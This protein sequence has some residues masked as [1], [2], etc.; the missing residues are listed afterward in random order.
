MD[1]ALVIRR[2]PRVQARKLAGSGGAV[3][4]NLDTAAYHGVNETGWVIWD[5]VGD[6]VSFGGL[7]R[8]VRERILDGPST[9]DEE[10]EAFVSALLE[11]HLLVAGD[12][13]VDPT[14]EPVG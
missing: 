3:L 9:L 4:L 7:L 8:S 13:A 12:A 1:D 14:A 5:S 10:V 2:N 11:R 6:G